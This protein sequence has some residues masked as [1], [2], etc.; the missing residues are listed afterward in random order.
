MLLEYDENVNGEVYYQK[1][2]PTIKYFKDWGIYT[3]NNH[4]IA[5]I[6]GAYSVD[7]EWRLYHHQKWFANEQLS[8]DEMLQCT[9]DLMG[10]TVDFVF[11][12]TCPICWE[13]RD[14]FL[15]A[16]DQSKVDKTMELFLEEIAKILS[17]KVWCFGHFHANRLE[18]PRVE[19][20]FTDTEDLETTWQRWLNADDL[21]WW[22]VKSP[23]FYQD[24]YILNNNSF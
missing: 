12:H 21:A 10:Q 4:R 15:A 20:Y 7:K 3:I 23:N 19:Q 24:D 17:W 22:L 6:G 8:D 16:I 5:V 14:L 11:T 1:K 2:W 18:R 13:P 9:A